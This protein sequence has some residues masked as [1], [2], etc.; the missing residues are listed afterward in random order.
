M[1]E[2]ATALAVLPVAPA[3]GLTEQELK[4]L[5]FEQHW[6]ARRGDK[7]TAIARTMGMRVIPYYQALNRLLESPAALAADP[8][9]INRLRRQRADM[10]HRHRR[11]AR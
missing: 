3:V 4:I 8:V 6:Y 7:M 9:T 5:A 11:W 10:I 2:V 1:S